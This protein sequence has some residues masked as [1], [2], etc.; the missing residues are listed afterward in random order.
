MTAWKFGSVANRASRQLTTRT[1]DHWRL[2]AMSGGK[3]IRWSMTSRAPNGPTGTLTTPDRWRIAY[4][5]PVVCEP[6]I[7]QRG[8]RPIS[9]TSVAGMVL[10]VSGRRT[11]STPESV[12]RSWIGAHT[13]RAVIRTSKIGAIHRALGSVT[14]ASGSTTHAKTA[15]RTNIQL[16]RGHQTSSFSR[17]DHAHQRGDHEPP[18]VHDG[19]WAPLRPMLW[20]GF[21]TVAAAQG[22]AP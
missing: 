18:R 11:M 13:V 12:R 21:T 5:G 6:N 17:T 15:H 3:A 7:P 9:Y 20:K 1:R 22:A 16:P 10:R 19:S 8:T 14:K 4:C 2:N